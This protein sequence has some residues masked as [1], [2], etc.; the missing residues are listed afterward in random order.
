[1]PLMKKTVLIIDDE[2]DLRELLKLTLAKMAIDSMAVETIK[3]A[4]AALQEKTFDLCLTDMRLPD[5]NGLALVDYT[6]KHYPQLPI[7]VLTAY[8]NVD[9]A[10]DALKLGAFDFLSKPV[11]LSRL[12]A[13][14]NNALT[15]SPE[16]P[17]GATAG[18]PLLLGNSKL[19]TDI[20]QQISKVARS[21]APMFISGESGTGKELAAR[22]IHRQSSRAAEPFVP[23]NCGAIHANLVESEFF[24]HRKGSFTGAFEDKQG[25]FQA[26]NGGT[27]F[28]DEVA[29]LPLDMQ[30]KLLRA[31]QEKRIR[32]VGSENEIDVDVRLISATHKNLQN[33]VNRGA[34]R[35]D[36]FYRLNVIDIQMPSL[37][38]RA[39]DIQPLAEHIL[40]ELNGKKR[41]VSLSPGAAN[42]L[43]NYSFPGNVR[44]LENILERACTLCENSRIE[45]EDL[46]LNSADSDAATSAS[47]KTCRLSQ[48]QRSED[49]IP[50]GSLDDHLEEIE[51]EI[52]IETLEQARWN[53]TEAAKKLGI[54]FRSIR[55]RLEKLGLNDE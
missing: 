5:G 50:I 4:K 33:E 40:R 6:Q 44:E 8:G 53:R 54:S 25:L 49:L 32:P 12:R 22:S 16:T 11:E 30:V 10:V 20:R 41:P 15:V 35:S 36:L 13:L 26:A 2:L 14:I 52:L 21:Q 45:L 39:E 24:G 17:T 38:Q 31:I 46:K 19:M 27:L 51:K 7:A 34:F 28:L 18:T 37:R 55:Y 47:H 9:L 23:V 43:L 3:E 48:A 42:A 1:M 29:D